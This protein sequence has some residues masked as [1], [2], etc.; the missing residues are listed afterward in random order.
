MSDINCTVKAHSVCE[1]LQY[2][3]LY[4]A[5]AEIP[6]GNYASAEI[7]CGNDVSAEIPCGNYAAEIRCGDYS[8]RNSSVEYY[9]KWIE[10]PE[11][12]KMRTVVS[13]PFLSSDT[14][15][16]MT[17]RLQ[18]RDWKSHTIVGNRSLSWYQHSN[19]TIP[20]LYSIIP[21]WKS[22]RSSLE[23]SGCYTVAITADFTTTLF[24]DHQ[25]VAA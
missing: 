22:E 23:H 7:P 4:R 5:D 11:E 9:G 24:E 1:T 14:L 2:T 25:P 17:E 12:R 16:H 13:C 8:V 15:S 21:C 6:C 18:S 10:R 19:S 3:V 20:V